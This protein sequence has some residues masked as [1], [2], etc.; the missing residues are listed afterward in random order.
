[1]PFM[2]NV[3][4]I[5]IILFHL[6][7]AQA[8]FGTSCSTFLSKLVS[9]V[10]ISTYKAPKLEAEAATELYEFVKQDYSELKK[11]SFNDIHYKEAG[12]LLSILPKSTVEHLKKYPSERNDVIEYKK[13]LKTSFNIG[14]NSVFNNIFSIL[15]SI[16]RRNGNIEIEINQALENY[17]KLPV[18]TKKQL[19][20]EFK[21]SQYS[22]SN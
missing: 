10:G 5:L 17:E 15:A 20:T 13:Y 16:K 14:S 4:Y 6:N 3:F 22:K 7:N 2:K 12:Y 11:I 18:E 19:E 21:K 1:M 9:I 8:S